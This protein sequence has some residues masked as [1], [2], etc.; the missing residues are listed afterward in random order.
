MVRAFISVDL[1]D[2]LIVSRLARIRDMIASTGRGIKPVGNENLHITIRF[3]GEIDETLIDEVY[4]VMRRLEFKSFN[5]RI[6]GLGG[7][8][9]NLRPRVVWAGVEEGSEELRYIRDY[10]ERGL[11]RLGFKPEKEKFVPHI[12]LARVK[13]SGVYSRLS[14][15]IMEYEDYEF[16][17]IKVSAVYLKKSILTPKGPV[18]I[19]LKKVEAK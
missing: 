18:Y 10:I 14:K 6:K 4:D 15:I 13:A 17:V 1:E 2:P 7:F 16:G 11:R 9:T 8:P 3:L 5:A 12:T 19:V